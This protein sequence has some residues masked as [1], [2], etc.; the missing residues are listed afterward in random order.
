MS[1][2]SIPAP[3]PDIHSAPFARDVREG[4]TASPKSLPPKWFYDSL[5]SVLFEAICRLPEYYL[6]RAESAILD[7]YADEIAAACGSP[8][9]LVELG[10]GSSSKTRKLIDAI[11]RK[12]PRLDFTTVDIDPT[13]LDTAAQLLVQD[14]EGLSIEALEGDFLRPSLVLSE[15]LDPSTRTLVLFLGSTIGNLDRSEA[16]SMLSDLRSGLRPGDA[17]LLGADLLKSR[18]VLEPAYDDAIG[19]TAAFNLNLLKRIN[20]E[21]GG[22]FD[23]RTFQHRAVLNEEKSRI[24]MH[25][26]SRRAQRVR[27]AALDLDVAFEAGESIHTENSYKYSSEMLESLAA[28]A[29]FT[30]THT[31]TDD[32]ARFADLLLVA[33]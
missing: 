24:E 22:E 17:L 13:M 28:E 27:I 32:E 9:Q 11:F 26:V 7:A 20:A 15:R 1:A 2:L 14:Y 4:L 16:V 19:V 5:G 12:Q 3:S 6:T 29:G 21:L 23:L 33:D 18:E 25:L 31:W 8:L 30:I 10:S